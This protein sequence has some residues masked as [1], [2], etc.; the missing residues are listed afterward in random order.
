MVNN[1]LVRNYLATS[2]DLD[3]EMKDLKHCMLPT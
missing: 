2:I 1:V 3:V